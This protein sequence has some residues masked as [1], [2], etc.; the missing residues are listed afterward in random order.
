[1][2]KLLI[3]TAICL[4]LLCAACAA[5]ADVAINEQNFPDIVFRGHVS[6]RF[7]TNH[8]DV[9][10]DAEIAEITMVYL[11]HQ[12]G[13]QDLT[14][15]EYFSALRLVHLYQTGV[16][17]LDLS[18]NPAVNELRV[19]SNSRLSSL[20]LGS[21]PNLISI[22]C[23]GN[24]LSSLNLTGCPALE[25]LVCS[26]NQLTRLDLSRNTKLKA[27]GCDSNQLTSLKLGANSVM[28]DLYCRNNQLTSLDVN[29]LPALQ[30]LYCEH[31]QLTALD[32]TGCP[33]LLHLSCE[34]NRLAFLDV[35][36]CPLL[37]LFSAYANMHEITA[38]GGKFDLSSLPGFDAARTSEWSGGT[39]SGSVLTL[40]QS[41]DLTYTYD[42]GKGYVIPFTLRVTVPGHLG[43]VEINEENFPD[44]AFRAFI[45]KDF[46]KNGNGVLNDEERLGVT[47]IRCNYENIADLT[48]IAYFPDL[49]YLD[50]DSNQ[51][52]ALDV[53]RNPALETLLCYDNQIAALDLSHNPALQTLKCSRNRLTT[54]DLSHNPLL[55]I[56]QCVSNQLSSLN[57]SACSALEELSCQENQ[58]PALNVA[59]NPALTYLCC[60][61][62]QLASLD[63]RGS[64]A[65]KT[66]DCY[67][68]KL[69][70][71]TLGSQPVLEALNCQSNPL[72]SLD[73]SQAPQLKYLQCNST[74]LVCL[75]VSQNPAIETFFCD[76]NIREIAARGGAV[77]LSALPGF[78]VSRTSEWQG[79]T[80][81]GATLTV[82]QSGDVTYVYACG[83]EHVE[84]FTLRVTVTSADHLPGDATGDG[85]VNL[86]DV[87]RLLKYVSGWDVTVEEANCD[88]TGDGSITLSDVV[89][90]LKYVSDWDV[91]L[92]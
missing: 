1:M 34:D 10:S 58:L 8:D 15:I 90:L 89:R 5:S 7:D 26:G 77:D 84:R 40:P 16:T 65:L 92:Q 13:I 31:N 46:D 30:Y 17:S 9:L 54:L 41:A 23:D 83:N 88:V 47:D 81:S 66:I 61:S 45:T 62:N 14:G 36:Q 35:T 71:L 25:S 59:G 2:K 53:S 82:A 48:G 80:V 91:V 70:V 74:R 49:V 42:C 21:K 51:L 4:L 38:E 50:C 55:R 68:N 73:L 11:E 69:A 78:D 39:L 44:A 29:L 33:A 56:L 76:N 75:D 57:V 32:V 43:G 6:V 18:Q 37:E 79:G 22:R 72:L 24:A 12:M 86:S 87:V 28:T 27:L 19:Y 60:F 85:K 20:I 63:L 67:D 3:G 52:T 64:P